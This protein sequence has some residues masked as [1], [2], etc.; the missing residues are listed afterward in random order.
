MPAANWAKP[1]FIVV[2]GYTPPVAFSSTKPCLAEGKGVKNRLSAE[3]VSLISEQT[4][5]CRSV[6]RREL[7]PLPRQ[8]HRF[9][10]TY[11]YTYRFSTEGIAPDDGVATAR[12]G[13]KEWYCT[14]SVPNVRTGIP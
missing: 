4:N 12:R 5:Y 13:I 6:L 10:Y 3:A 8:S 9:G 1:L 14:K 11:L 7:P 2:T